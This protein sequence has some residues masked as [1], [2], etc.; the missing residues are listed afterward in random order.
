LLSFISGATDTTT[1]PVVAPTGIVMVIEVSLQLLTITG[2]PLSNTR[3]PPCTAPKPEP[4]ITTWL[5][6]G[7]VVAD[8]PLM[9]GAGAAAELTDTLSNVAVP[10][11][12]LFWLT[13]TKPT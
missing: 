8:R 10:K 1:G 9:T 11:P 12:E 4:E 3:L 6:T 2:D 5:P 13:T 7:P